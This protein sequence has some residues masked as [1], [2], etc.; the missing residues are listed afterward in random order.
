MSIGLHMSGKG[1][2]PWTEDAGGAAQSERIPA[3]PDSEVSTSVFGIW[4]LI[5]DGG[6]S[7]ESTTQLS[8]SSTWTFASIY[9]VTK[10]INKI[11]CLTRLDKTHKKMRL[12]KLT[13]LAK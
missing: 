9:L 3:T 5:D 8:G 6:E 4:T 13:K 1:S 7:V 2:V 11:M 10:L 12:I